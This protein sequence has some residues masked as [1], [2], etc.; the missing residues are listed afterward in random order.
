MCV[1]P[2]SIASLLIMTISGV[3]PEFSKM[4]PIV[5][6]SLL[7]IGFW[8]LLMLTISLFFQSQAAVG[9]IGITLWIIP[10]ALGEL[11]KNVLGEA[12]GRWFDDCFAPNCASWWYTIA[13]DK[14][15]MPMA[16]DAAV[17]DAWMIAFAIWSAVL[18]V[19]S[20][21]VFNRQEIGS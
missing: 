14:D 17:P 3:T 9:A 7:W 5:G 10:N 1:L 21:W 13:A 20:L 4:A 12:K 16:R 8:V 15:L 6:A 18:I 19:F 2:I 11:L